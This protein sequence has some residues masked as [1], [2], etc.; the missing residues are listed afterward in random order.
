MLLF[1]AGPAHEEVSGWMDISFSDL[2]QHFLR[3]YLVEIATVVFVAMVVAWLMLLRNHHSNFAMPLP[4]IG[5]GH[6]LK[7]HHQSN[8]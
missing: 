8:R 4:S 6:G 3:L 7:L 1:T 2:L 5:N